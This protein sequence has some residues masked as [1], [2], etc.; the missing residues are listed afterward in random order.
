MEDDRKVTQ[1]LDQ[2]QGF[3]YDEQTKLKDSVTKWFITLGKELKIDDRDICGDMDREIFMAPTV[4]KK[5]LAL[6]LVEAIDLVQRHECQMAK[7]EEIIYFLKTEALEDKEKL[8]RLQGQLLVQKDKELELFKTSV[9]KTVQTTVES[10]IKSYSAAV[11][12]NSASGTVCN[13]NILKKVMKSVAAEEDRSRNL[14]VFGLKEEEGEQLPAL[15]TAVLEEIGEKPHFEATRVG[16]KRPGSTTIRPVKITVPSSTAVQQILMKTGR[17]R[18]VETHKNVWICPDRSSEERATR[19]HLVTDLKKK[20]VE[21][22]HLDHYIR[23]GK[24][25]SRDK[26]PP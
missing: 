9:K 17:L 1:S 23:Y 12:Q 7:M 5:H 25:C 2:I 20:R 18:L 19:K 3:E 16:R 26:K 6:R 24:V 13:S 14:I 8:I 10:G 22:T 4:Y 11:Q 21:Q 15:V